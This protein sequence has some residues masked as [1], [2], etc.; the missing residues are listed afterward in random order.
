[1]LYREPVYGKSVPTEEISINRLRHAAAAAAYK[2]TLAKFKKV[3]G[4]V[5]RYEPVMMYYE[6]LNVDGKRTVYVTFSDS[7]DKIMKVTWSPFSKVWPEL[8]STGLTK[9]VSN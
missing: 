2:R 8:E 1:M 7:E 4:M 9:L 3:F 6:V 5:P